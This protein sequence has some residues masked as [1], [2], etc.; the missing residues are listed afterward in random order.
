MF[1]HSFLINRMDS[2][3]FYSQETYW[4]SYQ[5][6]AYIEVEMDSPLHRYLFIYRLQTPYVHK[7]RLPVGSVHSL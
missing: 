7:S 1:V 6:V 3:P 4:K 5:P 2:I